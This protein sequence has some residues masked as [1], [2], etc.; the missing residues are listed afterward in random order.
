VQA[1]IY[2][3]LLDPHRLTAV[4]LSANCSELT[5]DAVQASF[6]QL[7]GGLWHPSS[8]DQLLRALEE[9][10][11]PLG[12]MLES[13]LGQRLWVSSFRSDQRIGL[14]LEPV[15]P[16]LSQ[17]C[18]TGAEADLLQLVAA[19]TKFGTTESTS[20]LSLEAFSQQLTDLI[21]RVVG[22]E[23]VM[24]YRFDSDWNGTVLAESRDPA[25]AS[26][27]LGLTFPASDIPAPARALF[28]RIA[29]R[30]TID[31]ACDPVPLLYAP[32]ESPRSDLS[33]CPYRAVAPVHR[34]Y[35]ANMG[36]RGSLTLAL[37]VSGRLW[38]LIAC[39]HLSG[40][41]GLN[42]V[43]LALMRS[44]SAIYSIALARL[45]E[46][47]G[48]ALSEMV[49]RLGV[50]LQRQAASTSSYQFRAELLQPLAGQLADAFAC[51]GVAYCW[52]GQV[53]CSAGA[54]SPQAVEALMAFHDQWSQQHGR[55]MLATA[56]LQ[57]YG[58][59]LEPEDAAR[60]AGAVVLGGASTL[61]LFRRPSALPTSWAGDPEQRVQRPPH[62]TRL[63][64]RSSFELF[65]QQHQGQ[66]APWESGLL[67]VVAPL[68]DALDQALWTL[69]A[70]R[71]TH[72]LEQAR[73]QALQAQAE[74]VQAA[75][76][77]PLTGLANRRQ[78]Y[79]VLQSRRF[80]AERLAL[81]HLD[82]DGFKAV[83]DTFGHPTGDLLL[84]RL[85]AALKGHVRQGDLV[86]RL[87]GDE[88][89]VL[90]DAADAG[91]ALETLCRRL[92]AVVSK[93]QIVNNQVCQVG[94]SIGAAFADRESADAARLLAESDRALY[95]SKK[96]GKGTFTFYSQ[97]LEMA[98]NDD[99]Q[100]AEELRWGLEQGQLQAF[101]QPLFAVKTGRLL[102]A[103]ALLRWNHPRHGL[104]APGRFLAMAQRMQLLR[105]VDRIML[106]L[107]QRDYLEW[108]SQGLRVETLGINLSREQ[109][110]S[111]GFLEEIHRL[112]IPRRVLCLELQESLYMRQPDTS[113]LRTLKLIQSLG[114]RVELDDF[115]S[116]SSSVRSL[117]SV[118]PD[119]LKVDKDLVIP[120]LCH[121]DTNRLL[122]LVVGMGHALDLE[123][124]AEGVENAEHVE[125]VRELQCTRMQGYGLAKPM[126]AA[127]FL[128][129]A[130][131]HQPSELV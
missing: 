6:G 56:D 93:P 90:T 28:Q 88:F 68:R 79:A 126:D 12:L 86:V 34:L 23:R 62:S 103:E 98:Y 124:T 91:V 87:G 27:Y 5:G 53:S 81:L 58:L 15:S 42:P 40:P 29:A 36:V 65:V 115:G 73:L 54:P 102:G 76:H 31:Q 39:H 123:V 128:A 4:A 78:L 110:L 117:M 77:D 82:L 83:N 46:R 55:P 10:E 59:A 74:M 84:E 51:S 120:A 121:Q 104:M 41:R 85:A 114:I 16:E 112:Q 109:F 101:Y 35:L 19:T 119:G 33:D 108:R 9:D 89:A 118:R 24:V 47:D 127:A 32:G 106:N 131:T 61:V 49:R 69:E 107:I 94:L 37:T 3:V 30:P 122:R 80:P 43:L 60:A 66:S 17:Q 57:S 125:L 8:A 13:G 129:F 100:L 14:L 52:N 95:E 7:L 72:Q 22:Y 1:G 11:G 99:L 2:V 21:R 63:D 48:Y 26:S 75:L 113:L 18:E 130:Q 92:I 116:G 45:V 64:P 44:V 97:A 111:D 38:G 25:L 70:R 96:F 105:E 50:D 67:R 71:Q 20:D